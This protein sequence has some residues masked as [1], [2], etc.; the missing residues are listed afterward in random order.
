MSQLEDAL[1]ELA[2]Y[3]TAQRLTGA[4]KLALEHHV[5]ASVGHTLEDRRKAM[6]AYWRTT[7]GMDAHDTMQVVK[8]Q[9]HLREWIAK[10]RRPQEAR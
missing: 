5:E 8:G 10:A 9:E 4:A 2:R 6:E 7:G 3:A 1:Q